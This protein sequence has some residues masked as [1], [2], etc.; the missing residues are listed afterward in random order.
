MPMTE[1]STIPVSLHRAQISAAG[2][3]MLLPPHD[4]LLR[5]FDKRGMTALA[6]SLGIAVPRTWVAEVDTDVVRL[7]RELPYPVVLKPNASQ[8]RTASG[9]S[10]PTGAPSYAVRRCDAFGLSTTG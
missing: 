1:A 8:R 5:V 2:G 9:G 10:A 6:Q 3:T 4:V 7:A